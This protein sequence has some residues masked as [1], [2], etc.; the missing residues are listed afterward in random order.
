MVRALLRLRNSARERRERRSALLDGIRLVAAYIERGGAPRTIVLA[1]DAPGNAE[2]QCLL[3]KVASLEPVVLTRGLFDEL[4]SVTTP[5]GIIAEIS[6]PNV[7]LLEPDTAWCVLV[8][9]VQDPGNLGSILRSAAA[10]GVTHILLSAGCADAWSPR[11]LRAGMGAHF[12]LHV[13]EHADLAG[14]ARAFRGQIVAT[15][16]AA[17]Q[18]VFDVD[19]T[20]ATALALGNEGS[21]LSPTL[22]AEA[23]VLVGIPMPGD[24]ESLNV[25][26]A[27]A[28]CL[29]ERVRQLA[30]AQRAR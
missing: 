30:A 15:S 8:E 26:A 5:T 29:F 18:A 1:P 14:F 25:A 27:A 19:F 20:R 12:S 7:P 11:V 22:L 3:G 13:Q 10:A 9:D 6:I 16:S 21:G 17:E 4:S 2:I 24:V 28:V 23:D